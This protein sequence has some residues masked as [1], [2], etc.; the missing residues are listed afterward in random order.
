MIEI[1]R[2]EVR[3]GGVRAL[4][5][6]TATLDAP[7]TGLIGPNGAGKTTLLNVLSGFVRP[8]AGSVK[9]D[10]QDVAK[11]PTYRRSAFGIRR[12]FQTE[13]VVLNLSVWDN[14]AGMLDHVPFAPR[15]RDEVIRSALRYTALAD[16]AHWIGGALAAA[17]RRMV[18][19]ARCIVGAPKVVM[20]DEPGAGLS[21]SE[22]DFLWRASAAG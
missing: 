16:R 13:Q 4:N 22:S 19:I 12:T 18:E 8:T 3:F 21:E 6:L 7:V 11:L 9:V 15:Q 5:S 20:M 1:D 14:V 2:L 17:D 10:G